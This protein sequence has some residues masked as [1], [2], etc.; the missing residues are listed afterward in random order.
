[1]NSRQK[2]ARGEREWASVC[3]DHGYSKARRGQQHSGIEG[4]DVVGL[5]CIH[6][7]VKRVEKLNIED[8]MVQAR[9]DAHGKIPIVAHRRN[10]EC[11]KVT[12]DA[13]DWF[14][15]FREWELNLPADLS[16]KEL[17]QYISKQ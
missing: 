16:E 5:P 7:E 1:M 15:L 14:K 3:R 17:L 4:E 9:R 13:E 10:N 6:Q 2:G 8:A 11:W 12:M